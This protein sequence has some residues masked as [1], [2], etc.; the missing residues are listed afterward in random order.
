MLETDMQSARQLAVAAKNYTVI[1]DILTRMTQ[2]CVPTAKGKTP[3]HEQRL[4]RNM[5]AHGVVLDLLQVPYDKAEDMRMKEVMVDA[6]EFLQHFCFGYKPNQAL[7]YKNLDLFIHSSGA[8]DALMHAETVRHIF[9]D[10]ADLCQKVT[11]SVVH[12]FIH[13]I[14]K[15]RHVKFL[16]FLQTIVKAED[17]HLRRIQDMVMQEL[18]NAGDDVLLFYNDTKGYQRLIELMVSERERSDD[19]SDLSYHINLV[20]LLALC[21]EGKNVYTEIKCHSLL[22]LEDIARVVTHAEC[23]PEVKM[24]YVNFLNHCYVDTEVEMKEIFTL[25]FI[26]TLFE[27][28]LLDIDTVCSAT[29]DDDQRDPILENYITHIVMQLLRMFFGSPFAN[30]GVIVSAHQPMFVR[31]LDGCHRVYK[32]QWASGEQKHSVMQTVKKLHE[33]ASERAVAVSH[34]LQSQLRLLLSTTRLSKQTG[35][36]WLKST[37]GLRRMP[38]LSQDEPQ[39]LDAYQEL[40]ML[41]ERKTGPEVHAEMSVLVD[42]MYSPELLFPEVTVGHQRAAGG[43]FMHKLIGH[44]EQL[45]Q[46]GEDRLV[47]Q[48]LK[49]LQGTAEAADENTTEEGQAIRRALV[50][51]YFGQGASQ[52]NSQSVVLD[53]HTKSKREIQ[54]Y[55]D[56]CKA[57]D[58]VI[59]LIMHRPAQEVFLESIKLGIVILDEGNEVVQ[60][61]V[62]GHHSLQ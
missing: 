34:E 57:S 60:V 47:V 8:G 7:L 43:G 58:L 62:V 56:Y 44:T 61:L 54:N 17:T 12:H 22:P 1:C 16:H 11:E 9:L 36:K 24:A 31:L 42:V 51:Q 50:A 26:W 10:N 23:L 14:Q 6:H 39:I 49:T 59:N 3:L 15:E 45:L 13:A 19:N 32:C 53:R 55:L 46:D 25:P 27:N 4:L 2:L 52:S 30:L 40:L 33:I 48:V 21:T 29:Y 5:G 41:L 35:Q 28:F 37:F 38:T 20:K 18:V